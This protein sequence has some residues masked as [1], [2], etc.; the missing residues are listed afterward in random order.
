[1]KT[2]FQ[3]Y[4]TGIE[5]EVLNN[6]TD[7]SDLFQSYLTGIE[8]GGVIMKEGDIIVPIVPNWN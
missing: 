7:V 3:S 1:M 6:G 4:L 8:I 5:I 2:M